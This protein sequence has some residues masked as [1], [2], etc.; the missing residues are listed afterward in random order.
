MPSPPHSTLEALRAATRERHALLDSS[1]AFVRS[2]G[3][4]PLVTYLG[5]MLGYLEPIEAALWEHPDLADLEPETR[6]H[7]A[8]WIR[9]DLA[10]LGAAD[11]FPR[12]QARPVPGPGT[13]GLAYVLEGSTL[14]GRVLARQE[15]LGDLRFFAGYGERTGELWKALV[16]RL[17][18]VGA[19]PEARAAMVTGACEA[20]DSVRSWLD[21]QGAMIGGIPSVEDAR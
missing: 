20:F 8:Q 7:K 14:G 19:D 16:E 4:E 9:D 15:G 1:L 3:R 5:A 21:D 12:M 6:N 2:T 17:E 10:A 18:A 13:L 11:V